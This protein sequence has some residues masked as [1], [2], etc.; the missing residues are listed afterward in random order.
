MT[1]H[2]AKFITNSSSTSLI[3]YGIQLPSV[4]PLDENSEPLVDEF[5]DTLYWEDFY[6]DKSNLSWDKCPVYLSGD[7]ET[8]IMYIKHS[9]FIIP[10]GYNSY[11]IPTVMPGWDDIIEAACKKLGIAPQKPSWFTWRES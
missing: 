5:G 6:H 11:V 8:A 10:Y 7:E 1:Y 9:Q 2:R 3:A 4:S